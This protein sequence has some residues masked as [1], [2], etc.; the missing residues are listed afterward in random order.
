MKK[1]ILLLLA[2]AVFGCN[3]EADR[4][5]A[6]LKKVSMKMNINE[7]HSVMR[8]KPLSL[9]KA[10]WSDLLLVENYQSPFAAADDYKIIYLKKDT[11]VVRVEWGD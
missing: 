3:K 8:N 1:N 4:N 10:Y 7:V 9:E 2:V 5:Y 6:D 11:T